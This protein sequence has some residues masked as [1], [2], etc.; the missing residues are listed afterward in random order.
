VFPFRKAKDETDEFTRIREAV[1]V[2]QPAVAP[3]GA[4]SEDTSWVRPMM[5]GQPMP[6]PMP[7]QMPGQPMQ[8]TPYAVASQQNMQV[9]QP[10]AS[11]TVV[12]QDC[13]IDGRLQSQ[14][15]I[16]IQGK[17]SGQVQA[18][19]TVYVAKEARVEASIQAA[20]V[21]VAGEV[22]GDITCS[23]KLEVIPTGR[24]SGEVDAGRLVIH[25]GAYVNSAFKM[26]SAAKASG[27]GE[28]PVSGRASA[29][30]PLNGQA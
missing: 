28:A 1:R 15:S 20:T 29:S 27:R 26:A 14:G 24:I 17:V 4:P 9:P 6:Q 21:I 25:E 13:T 12:F 18:G 5:P 11:G 19:D 10:A 23:G 30:T 22:V 8:Q 2:D 3:A 7:G 16:H